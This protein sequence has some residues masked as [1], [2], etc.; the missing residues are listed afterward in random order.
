MAEMWDILNEDGN[1]TGRLHERGQPMQK[2]EY[3]LGV[4]V[5]IMN[6]DGNFL[7]AKRTPNRGDIWHTTG[8]CAIA[9]DDSLSAALREVQEEIG[10]D[11]NPK[12]GQL[13]KRCIDPHTNDEGFIICDVW[14]FRQE[15]DITDTVLC[16]N[17]ISDACWASREQIQKMII[18][19]T[20]AQPEDRWYPYLDELFRFCETLE[21]GR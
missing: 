3:H 11:L 14:L 4:Q 5:W 1:K 20:F 7:I 9:G 13:F 18:D 10:V 17:E 19:G 12:S 8:G 2:G 15:V 21:N 6:K 16:P